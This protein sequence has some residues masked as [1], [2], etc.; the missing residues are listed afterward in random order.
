MPRSLRSAA[1]LNWLRGRGVH[2]LT[3]VSPPAPPPCLPSRPLFSKFPMAAR[4]N[5][6]PRP[7]VKLRKMLAGTARVRKFPL[8]S[9]TVTPL[10]P[11]RL[12]LHASAYGFP[13]SRGAD[14]LSKM[15]VFPGCP[16]FARVRQL[17][18]LSYLTGFGEC[19]CNFPFL[20]SAFRDFRRAAPIY[21]ND[22][23]SLRAVPIGPGFWLLVS[24]D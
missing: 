8:V 2:S 18:C 10:Q 11:C 17:V 15:P 14:N 7:A 12:S 16:D 22:C 1:C 6:S 20:Q 21:V 13:R 24:R 5:T 23:P 4:S 19:V 9:R 3:V